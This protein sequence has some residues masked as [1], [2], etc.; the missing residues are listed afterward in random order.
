MLLL[1]EYPSAV[2]QKTKTLQMS[3][4]LAS[5]M[6]TH[7]AH[8][9]GTAD[10]RRGQQPGSDNSWSWYASAQKCCCLPSSAHSHY[11]EVNWWTKVRMHLPNED[12]HEYENGHS[13]SNNSDQVHHWVR[14]LRALILTD[15]FILLLSFDNALVAEETVVAISSVDWVLR[16]CIVAAQTGILVGSLHYRCAVSVNAPIACIQTDSLSLSGCVVGSRLA[17]SCIPGDWVATSWTGTA[18]VSYLDLSRLTPPEVDSHN[19]V[20]IFHWV[21]VLDHCVVDGWGLQ[22][23]LDSSLARSCCEFGVREVGSALSQSDR[24]LAWYFR[25]DIQSHNLDDWLAVANHDLVLL[26]THHS[27]F[28]GRVD[29]QP[30]RNIVQFHNVSEGRAA[31]VADHLLDADCIAGDVRAELGRV[32]LKHIGSE[33]RLVGVVD[34]G[35]TVA[36]GSVVVEGGTSDLISSLSEVVTVNRNGASISGSIVNESTIINDDIWINNI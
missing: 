19:L 21:Q 4:P 33:D 34:D 35:T 11:K 15:P 5:L 14:S 24:V 29:D 8:R 20:G 12:D 2:S 36:E 22:S 27:Q 28:D 18:N 3:C 16:G 23:E 17:L 1:F 10:W 30:T 9:S 7:R 6:T 32:A 31:G 13:S 25:G 26:C